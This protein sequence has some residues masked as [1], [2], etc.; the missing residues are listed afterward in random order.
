MN[1]KQL[2]QIGVLL[3]MVIAFVAFAKNINRAVKRLFGNLD[4]G[5]DVQNTPVPPI[6]V[7]PEFDADYFVTRLWE[8]TSANY[9]LDGGARC[10]AYAELMSTNDAEFVIVCNEFWR[11]SK[12]SLRSAMD[13]TWYNGCSIFKTQWDKKIYN[14]MRELNVKG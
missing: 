7:G 5:P 14:R 9:Y 1:N 12:R 11:Q 3:V 4:E 10:D 8:V 6:S 13:G 2:L